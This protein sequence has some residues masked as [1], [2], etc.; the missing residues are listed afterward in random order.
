MR[1]NLVPRTL[2]RTKLFFLRSGTSTIKITGSATPTENFS[3]TSGTL[4]VL[5]VSA[6][7]DATAGN[8]TIKGGKEN[9]VLTYA[10]ETYDECSDD[11]TH[12]ITVT[13]FRDLQTSAMRH[14]A[15]TCAC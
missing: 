3:G 1:G 2:I 10:N 6:D 5:T 8:L 13:V 12:Q 4:C 9:S 7:N 15:R 11:E 14:P